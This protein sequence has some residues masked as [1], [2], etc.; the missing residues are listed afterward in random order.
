MAEDLQILFLSLIRS[1][2]STCSHQQNENPPEHFEE[3]QQSQRTWG[4]NASIGAERSL[5]LIRTVNE[6]MFLSYNALPLVCFSVHVRVHEKESSLL[7][8]NTP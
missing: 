1:C 4:L 6:V 7:P 8:Q 2:C 3:L 5:E